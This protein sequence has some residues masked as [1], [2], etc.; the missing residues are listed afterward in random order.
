MSKPVSAVITAHEFGCH[1]QRVSILLGRPHDGA[2]ERTLRRAQMLRTKEPYIGVT[3]GKRWGWLC[4]D[5]I[6]P[7]SPC[8][9]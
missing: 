4:R 7:D 6:Q 3:S 1:F 9:L 8:F 5:E 2:N